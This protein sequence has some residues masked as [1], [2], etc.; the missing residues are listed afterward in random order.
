MSS[1]VFKRFLL[2]AIMCMAFVPSL[3]AA[4]Q[5]PIRGC[6]P[7][8]RTH[9][10]KKA[11]RVAQQFS[12]ASDFY[13][14]DLRQL[15]VLASFADR[16]FLQE[17]PTEQ[18]EMIF[19]EHH[20]DTPPFFGSVR[21]Y[22]FDQSYGKLR[23]NFDILHISLGANH[24]KYGST[25]EDDENSQFLV[26][27]IVDSLLL[28]DIDWSV[29]DWN[30]D[31]YVNQLLIIYAGK[32]SSYGNFGGDSDAIWP[33]QWWLSE[34]IDPQTGLPLEPRMVETGESTYLIDSYCAVQEL[35]SDNS[36]GSFGTICHE[37]SHCFGFPDFYNSYTS[38]PGMWDLMDKGNYNHGGFC[39]AGYSAH[40][41]MLMGW[42]TPTELT[43]PTTVS[44]MAPLSSDSQA[45]LVR[46]DGFDDEYYIIENRQ[47]QS[48]D[49]YLPGS[50]IIIFHIDYDRDLW[51]EGVPNSFSRQCYTIIPANNRTY[52]SL[53]YGWA[54]PFATNDSLTNSS[55]PAATLFHANSDNTL[56]M[57]K[58]LYHFSVDDERLASFQFL[59]PVA[60]VDI[61]TRSTHSEKVLWRMGPV[62]IVRTADGKV[63]KVIA[64]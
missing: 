21:D 55:Q 22:F 35:Y 34:H 47:Q 15:V 7:H 11:G 40:E 37:Y 10:A 48:W 36:Y 17:D 13:Q 45:F 51:E 3:L 8:P 26:N 46:N 50:G 54:Y 12:Q 1:S 56:F 23:L 30:G 5:V 27:D 4:E 61:P 24:A 19:N 58:P 20:L 60:S 2:A 41:R 28:K 6:R 31:G 43:S 64:H 53:S 18:W 52:T 44:S 33:H 9:V 63:K 62:S 16:P 38:Y 57:S 39:P 14:G 59:S 32:G 29:Y 49:T 25:K 42:L